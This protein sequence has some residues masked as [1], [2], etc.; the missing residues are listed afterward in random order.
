VL[1]LIG[2]LPA[3]A[4]VAGLVADKYEA[5]WRANHPVADDHPAAD[6]TGADRRQ[7]GSKHSEL[8]GKAQLLPVDS[9]P[10]MSITS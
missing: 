9:Q 7:S 2:F 4:A 8:S 10:S 3:A 5:A 1:T 6:N